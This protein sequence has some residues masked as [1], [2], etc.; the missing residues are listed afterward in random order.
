VNLLQKQ[1]NQ[2]GQTSFFY[3]ILALAL[4]VLAYYAIKHFK[5][6]NNNITIHI[7]KVEVH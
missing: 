5:D 1:S 7:P 3:V 6:K 2:K 4:V